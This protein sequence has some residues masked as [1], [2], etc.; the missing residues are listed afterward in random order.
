M[1]Y[2]KYRLKEKKLILKKKL[3]YLNYRKLF[4]GKKISRDYNK[5]YFNWC[6]I[7]NNLDKKCYIDGGVLL[8]ETGCVDVLVFKFNKLKR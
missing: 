3:W 8:G 4:Y 6:S 7:K 2:L 5:N 1:F